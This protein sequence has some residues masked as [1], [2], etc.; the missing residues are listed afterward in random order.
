MEPCEKLVEK[1]IALEQ[2]QLNMD[3]FRQAEKEYLDFI[4]SEESDSIQNPNE[5]V[6]NR[7]LCFEGRKH[8]FININGAKT[9]NEC[10]LVSGPVPFV[11]GY[12]C[13]NRAVMNGPDRSSISYRYDNF[14]HMRNITDFVL[15]GGDKFKI[16]KCI[17]EVYNAEEPKKGRLPNLNILTYQICKRLNIEIDESLLKIPNGKI[18]HDRCKKIFQTLG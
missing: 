16:E 10:G 18:P 1:H 8:Q 13:W 9:C 17:R 2:H 7:K 5:E 11:S 12:G 4:G 6:P 3:H 14:C 15:S